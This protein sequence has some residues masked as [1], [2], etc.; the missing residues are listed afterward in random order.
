MV[1]EIIH[2]MTLSYSKVGYMTI[3]IDLEKAYDRLEWS[4]IRHTLQFFNF[5]KRWI[6]LIMSCISTTSLSVL[7]NGERLNEFASSRC[8]RQ[9]DPLSPYIFILCM[10]YLV[11]LIH[12]EVDAGNWMGVKTSRFG[13]LFAHLYFA[14]DLV[15]FAKA[16]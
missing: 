14:D 8:I 16:T 9:G 6:D 15:L 11:W 12:I 13:P 2:S 4:F 3:K 7:I 10:E 5:P 1:Q